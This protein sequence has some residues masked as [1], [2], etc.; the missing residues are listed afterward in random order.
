MKNLAVVGLLALVHSPWALAQAPLAP[1]PKG[2]DAPREGIAHGTVATVE[3]PSSTVGGKR[4]MTVYAPPGFSKDARYPVFYLLHGATDD[5][6]TWMKKGKAEAILDNMYADKKIVPMIVVMPNSYTEEKKDGAKTGTTK[7]FEDDLLK[8]VIP[9]VESHYPVLADREHRAIVG[10]SMGGGQALRIGLKNLDKFAWIGGL[11][12]A[13]MG[14]APTMT[15]PDDLN[16]KLRL[17][18]VSCGDKD[19]LL[20]GNTAF[21][22]NLTEKNVTHIWHVDSGPHDWAVPRNDLYLIGMMLFRD[23]K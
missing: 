17:L 3:Y 9:Y 13:L 20:K 18:W 6:N 16:T 4:P 15:S 12:S 5:H 1:A 2:F 11:S 19:T 14:G 22:N 21:H 8:D 23:K 7:R 10:W